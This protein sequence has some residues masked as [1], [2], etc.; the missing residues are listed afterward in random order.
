VQL[1]HQ[2]NRKCAPH[3]KLEMMAHMVGSVD[4][5]VMR[6]FGPYHKSTYRFAIVTLDQTVTASALGVKV[7]QAARAVFDSS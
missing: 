7:S 4:Y 2:R 1:S 6:W 5:S 3:Q